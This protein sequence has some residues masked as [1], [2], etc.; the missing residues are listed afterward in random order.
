[1][2]A[3]GGNGGFTLLEMI[4]AM[5]L[6]AAMAG[7]LAVAFRMASASTERGEAVT[8]QMARLR[9]GIAIVERAVR[10]ADAMPLTAADKP[11]PY[12][13]GERNRLRFLTA[14]PPSAA[15]GGGLRLL[16][17]FGSDAEGLALGDAPPFRAGGVDAWKG[18]EGARPILPGARKIAFSY[19]GGPD[20]D[21]AWGWTD[22]WDAAEKGHLPAAVRVELT[23][24]DPGGGSLKTAFVVPIFGGG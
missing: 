24:N 11:G 4:V 10:S 14:C 23:T 2:R 1:M 13:L 17:L 9:A 16:S 22:T 12:F 20:K 6:M 8:R 7:F 18:T 3:R 15:Y 5:T 19:S 21:G